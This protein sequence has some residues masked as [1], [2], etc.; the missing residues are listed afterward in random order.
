MLSTLKCWTNAQLTTPHKAAIEQ[1][2]ELSTCSCT[3]VRID[4]Q[5]ILLDVIESYPKS[6]DSIVPKLVT[7]LN[8]YA[9]N[10]E[11]FKGA[12]YLLLGTATKSLLLSDNW[13]SILQLWPALVETNFVE[14]PKIVDL[15]DNDLLPLFSGY[16]FTIP[17]EKVRMTTNFEQLFHKASLA[18]FGVPSQI[19]LE[20]IEKSIESANKLNKQLYDELVHQFVVTLSVH[21]L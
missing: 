18:H 9:T 17:I 1:L 8:N 12:L 19:E 20:S 13:S 15:I 14:K 21:K 16:Y 11:A 4:A 2:L 6:F 10:Y 7:H 3:E 5:A